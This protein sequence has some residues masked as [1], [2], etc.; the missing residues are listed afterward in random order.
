[1]SF[2]IFTK[3]KAGQVALVKIPYYRKHKTVTKMA[4]ILTPIVNEYKTEK[5]ILTMS[6][7]GIAHCM[8]V[9]Y[10]NDKLIGYTKCDGGGIWSF[11]QN[12]FKDDYRLTVIAVDNNYKISEK[13]REMILGKPEKLIKKVALIQMRTDLMRD[14]NF[15]RKL[16]QI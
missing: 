2:K 5:G 13:T 16:Q 12:F 14:V 15:R 11:N 7:I 8:V 6:G 10:D 3:E 4:Q 9:I 1:M